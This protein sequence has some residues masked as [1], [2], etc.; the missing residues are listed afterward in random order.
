[1]I[2]SYPEMEESFLERR[3]NYTAITKFQKEAASSIVDELSLAQHYHYSYGRF[4]F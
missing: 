3:S 4:C 2:E 1:M